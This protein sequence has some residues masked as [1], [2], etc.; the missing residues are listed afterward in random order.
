[1]RVVGS[2]RPRV[3]RFLATLAALAAVAAVAVSLPAAWAA[4][5]AGAAAARID[6]VAAENTWGSLASQLGGSKVDVLS[7][8]SDPNTDPHDYE[9]NPGNARAMAASKL[10]IVNGAGYDDWALQLLSAQPEAGRRVLNVATLVGK[11]PGDNPHLWYD[12]TDVY[13]VINRIT[14]LF[15]AIDPADRAY[16][17]ARHAAVEA[18]FAP[19]RQRLGY[20]RA[21]FAGRPVAATESIF[22]YLAQYLGLDLVTPYSFM[23]AVAEGNDP[24]VPATA[25][26]YHQI[27]TKAFS[28]LV[29][30]VQTVTPLTTNLKEAAAAEDIPVV[31]I[32][33]TIQ[34]PIATF[35]QWMDGQP[36]RPH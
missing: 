28:V 7:V 6:V 26:F 29:Y 10:V 17:Q 15:R 24:P 2:T 8:V 11:S 35:E 3:A 5:P 36:G 30:N 12:P 19:Y 27:D 13:R 4:A 21:H 18:A 25:A 23:E 22:Q 31:G 32:S 1:M 34:P 14:T 16:F 20:I 9:S 33:E